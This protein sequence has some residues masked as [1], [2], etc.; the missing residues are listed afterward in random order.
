MDTE[1]FAMLRETVRRFVDER[2]IPNEDRV[3]EEDAVP[4][5]IIAEMRDLGLFGLTVPEQY[6]G[7]GLTASE[8]IQVIYELGRTSFAYRSVIGT[9]VGIGS[10]GIVMDGTE[11]QKAE[12]LP[13]LAEGMFASFALTEPNSGSDAASISTTAIQEGDVYRLNGT[14]RYITNAPRA[15]MFTVMA[16]TKPEVK[17]AAGITAFIL[18]ADTPGISFGKLDKKMGQKGTMTCDVIFDDVMVPAA[19]IIGGVPERGFKTA[20][21][22]LDRGR[23]HLS[24]L[25]SGM[26]ER[27]VKESVNYA[28]ERK[29]FGQAIGEFQLV[30]GM[31]AD[32]RTD[33]Y[34]AWVM[35]QDVARRFDAGEK[36]SRDVASTKYFASEALGRVADRA[37]QIHGGAG[38]MAE[39]KVE[40]FYRDVRLMR[41][42]EG[43][44]QVQQTIIAK[45][46]LR[47]AGLKI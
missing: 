25:S 24:A 1:T 23:I 13:K 32:S 38:Y 7:L 44:S 16:R 20:M 2:L 29:Q 3:E 17:G 26:C 18:P 39:Y 11:E 21:K 42:Y 8:E 45:A 41:I 14:K 35:T 6:G 10:Q 4:D 22:V 15:G 27:L 33:A 47:E 5:E 19:N 46:L 9:T 12:W 40:R 34:A 36:V 37:V 30:Q 43:T 28:V 31:I